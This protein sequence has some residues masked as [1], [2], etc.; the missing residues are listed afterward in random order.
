MDKECTAAKYS[1]YEL[2]GSIEDYI[3]RIREVVDERIPHEYVDT[4]KIEFDSE[5]D[6]FGDSYD[7]MYIKYTRPE[8]SKEEEERIARDKRMQ[9][10]RDKSDKEWYEK[11]KKKF[12]GNN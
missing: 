6:G 10:A 5:N 1:L 4:A 2:D 3:K 7:Y 11:L 8:T 12:E 9:E